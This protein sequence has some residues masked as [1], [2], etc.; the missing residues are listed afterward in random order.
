MLTHRPRG[1]VFLCPTESFCFVFLNHGCALR[2]KN[3]N[4]PMQHWVSKN[5]PFGQKGNLQDYALFYLDTCLDK[6]GTVYISSYVK[7]LRV[8]ITI[9]PNNYI[10][11]TLTQLLPHWQ[12]AWLSRKHTKL[13]NPGYYP[14]SCC[15]DLKYYCAQ[16]YKIKHRMGV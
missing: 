2:L 5:Q 11:M 4:I 7:I 9:P 13:W 10:N 16:V 15:Y 3:A 14:K 1:H 12:K 8:L 6:E